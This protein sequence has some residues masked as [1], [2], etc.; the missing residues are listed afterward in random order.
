MS[1]IPR[2]SAVRIFLL[3]WICHCMA[4]NTVIQSYFTAFLVKSDL[5][6][7]VSSVD[8]I[9]NSGMDYGFI[10][11]FD[12]FF[13]IDITTLNKNVLRDRK[14]CTHVWSVFGNWHTTEISLC[15]LARLRMK[16]V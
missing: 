15:C 12:I 6:K 4:V 14:D 5:E 2:A 7:Q 8:E 9:L 3:A 11:Q 16:L 13:T 1:S 10:P